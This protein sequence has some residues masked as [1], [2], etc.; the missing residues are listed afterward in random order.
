MGSAAA[1]GARLPPR[2]QD[3]ELIKSDPAEPGIPAETDEVEPTGGSRTVAIAVIAGIAIG[4]GVSAAVI[5]AL[6]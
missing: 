6:R 2:H 3:V 4:M 5:M 1:S